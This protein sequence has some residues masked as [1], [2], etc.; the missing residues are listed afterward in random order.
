MHPFSVIQFYS[1]L[2][3][4]DTSSFKYIAVKNRLNQPQAQFYCSNTFS[5]L[6][7]TLCSFQDQTHLDKIANLTETVGKAWGVRKYWIDLT[8]S[9]NTGKFTDGTEA[10][11]AT[12]KVNNYSQNESGHNGTCIVVGGQTLERRLC[13][14]EK[15]F[16]CKI[17]LAHGNADGKG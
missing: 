4:S 11:F 16:I 7:G 6:K 8:A 2:L 3:I 9:N 15:Y 5:S 14:D 13:T 10:T 17:T 12:N 1:S